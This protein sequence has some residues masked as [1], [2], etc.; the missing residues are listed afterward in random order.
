MLTPREQKALDN[1]TQFL[2]NVAASTLFVFVFIVIMG[3]VFYLGQCWINWEWVHY[4]PEKWR[5]VRIAYVVALF[6]S[7]ILGLII[8]SNLED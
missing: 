7:V 3:V 2:F 8:G 4:T 6:G 5:E 1:F